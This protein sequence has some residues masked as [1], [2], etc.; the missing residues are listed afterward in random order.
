MP[1]MRVEV[2]HLGAA[3]IDASQILP[4]GRSVAGFGGARFVEAKDPELGQAAVRAWNDWFYEEW[5][6]AHPDRFIP[7]GLTYLADPD[8]GAEE[9]RRN[10]ARGFRS[11]SLPERPH[12]IGLPTVF[13]SY[14]DPIIEACDETETVICL[15][16]G[17]SGIEARPAGAPTLQLGATLFGQ[18]SLGACAE[19]LWSGYG[20]HYPT[21]KIA[22]S[23]GGIGWVAMLLDRLVYRD[24]WPRIEGD[25]PSHTP[26][27]RP[28]VGS[29]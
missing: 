5:Y 11:V 3:I 6:L 9:I 28:A 21:L 24:G 10:A 29:R 19:W 16:V 18:L 17:S 12:R 4:T 23:E 7:N 27:Q 14:W 15:H 26:M 25:Q 13:D 1:Q 20:L 8:Q 2:R 22:M